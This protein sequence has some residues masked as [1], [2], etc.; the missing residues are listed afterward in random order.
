[1]KTLN[2]K[3]IHVKA[4]TKEPINKDS[5]EYFIWYGNYMADKLAVNAVI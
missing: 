1:M 4:H 3:F 2:I 5:Q